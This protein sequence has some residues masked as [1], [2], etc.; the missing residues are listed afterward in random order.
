MVTYKLQVR[1]R[2]GKVHRSETDVLPL[3]YT[4]NRVAVNYF[5]FV[6]NQLFI[7][8][9]VSGLSSSLPS[10]NSARDQPALAAGRRHR[11]SALQRW[12]SRIILDAGRLGRRFVYKTVADTEAGNASISV[13]LSTR[14]VSQQLRCSLYS[15]AFTSITWE[16]KG[17]NQCNS[18]YLFSSLLTRRCTVPIVNRIC[19][20]LVAYIFMTCSMQ[21]WTFCLKIS[22]RCGAT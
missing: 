8:L 21:S 2:P 7:S 1:C 17:H 12:R 20:F 15:L 13:A 18:R 16:I 14:A 3:S 10:N 9:N 19:G 4:A 11:R 5:C 6:F 22:S